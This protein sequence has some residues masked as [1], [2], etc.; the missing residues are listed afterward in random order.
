VLGWGHA[1]HAGRLLVKAPARIE[2]RVVDGFGDA[3]ARSQ[4]LPDLR[5]AVGGGV[6]F[7]RDAGGG[8]EH[9][10]EITRTT[11][12]RGHQHFQRRLL[13]AL[14]DYSAGPRNEGCILALDRRAVGIA[15]F[16]GPEAGS[17]CT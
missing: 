17:S 4:S 2:T 9:A 13:F 14:L 11:T 7:G 8:L 16:A 15:P 10:V 12:D 5:G 3:A 6:V 1:E